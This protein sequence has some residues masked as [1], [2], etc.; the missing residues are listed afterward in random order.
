MRDVRFAV[1]S[2]CILSST[3]ASRH[4]H[5][6]EVTAF[7]HTKI[8]FRRSPTSCATSTK[9]FGSHASIFPGSP[10]ALWCGTGHIADS[11]STMIIDC[12]ASCR[13]HIRPSVPRHNMQDQKCSSSF[14]ATRPTT[15]M[16]HLIITSGSPQKLNAPQTTTI[17]MRAVKARRTTRLLRRPCCLY[18]PKRHRSCS[19]CSDLIVCRL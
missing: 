10:L 13:K 11:Y 3:T 16:A 8:I 6:T 19:A 7:C 1:P 5:Q 18:A 17:Q 2:A 14:I 15:T 9:R 4:Q 12:S